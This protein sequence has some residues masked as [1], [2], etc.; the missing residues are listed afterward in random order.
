MVSSTV[1]IAYCVCVC[2]CVCSGQ[3]LELLGEQEDNEHWWRVRDEDGNEGCVPASYVIKKKEN[4]VCSRC[5]V[6]VLCMGS[7][8]SLSSLSHQSLPWLELAALK[9]EETERKERVKRLQQQK[10][11]ESGKGFGPPPKTLAPRPYVSAYNRTGPQSASGQSA[12]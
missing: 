9:S 8:C 1:N 10:D 5:G 7:T 4:Q 6:S 11:A 12:L 2:V 3:I